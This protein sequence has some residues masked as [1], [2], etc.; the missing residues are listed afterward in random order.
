MNSEQFPS[1][2]ILLEGEKQK[3]I[4][5]DRIFE[6]L[7][8]RPEEI[9]TLETFEIQST[10]S[11]KEKKVNWHD[12][13]LTLMEPKIKD[14][15]IL[16]LFCGSNSIKAYFKDKGLSGE[17]TGV[18]VVNEKADIKVDVEKLD[19]LLP[20]EKQF[21]IVCEFGGIPSKINYETVANYLKKDGFFIIE[22]SDYFYKNYTLPIIEGKQSTSKKAH[23]AL[24]KFKPIVTVKVL[25]VKSWDLDYSENS[26]YVICK[27]IASDEETK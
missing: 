11:A 4:I 24:N 10:I 21:D 6:I 1:G 9:T 20:P 27:K 22:S 18:D 19:K 7:E 15:K 16:D 14:S 3:E 23:V 8:K 2:E 12:D 26:A 25:G 5:K 17:V 13:F